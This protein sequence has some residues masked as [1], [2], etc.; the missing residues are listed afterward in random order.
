[1][2]DSK[3][4]VTNSAIIVNNYEPG[5]CVKLENNFKI[6]E[7]V[8]HSYY[9][10]GMHYD[11]DKKRLY[12]PRGIDIWYVEKLIGEKA[13]VLINQ[14]DKYH[15]YE[16]AMIKYLPR[17]ETQKKALRFMV[18]KEEY[19]KNQYKSQLSV[20]LSTGKG[21]TYLS[22]ATL[23]FLGIRGIII[24]ST[25]GWLD[26]WKD[27]TIEYTD[28]NP[29]DIYYISGSAN[30]SRL[31]RMKDK[32]LDRYK[33]FLVTHSTLR[34]YASNNGWDSI[35]ELFKK[36]QIGIK[37]FD[38]A[39][40]DFMNTCL[41]DFYT[42]TYK[43]YYLTATPNKSNERENDIYQLA[44]RNVPS[45]ELFDEDTDPHTSYVAVQFSSKPSAEQISKC[46]NKYGL[47]RN[48][49]TNYVVYQPEFYKL[50]TILL[51]LTWR[52]APGENDKILIY[53]GTNDAIRHTYD[54]VLDNF[55]ELDEMM[56][57][58]TS[59]ISPEEKMQALNKRF[60]FSTTKSAGAAL[61]IPGLKITINLAE[62]YKSEVIARQSLG[63][64]R[65]DNTYYIDAIDVGFEQCR[66]FYYKKL[67]IFEKYAK[68]CSVVKLNKYELDTRYENIMH[69]R[70]LTKATVKKRLFEY[71][72]PKKRL[73]EY[74]A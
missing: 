10:I 44:F 45:I 21:K 62:P 23:T 39:H 50:L 53:I 26:Q 7:P 52:L 65:D 69:A 28:M 33:L 51:D 74:L 37:I 72:Q 20:N 56:G 49:Y 19:Y 22:I 46:K 48:K 42:N 38:E 54:W 18:G 59:I 64:T 29:K 47:D 63:R 12:L 17:D 32:Q 55:P 41:I 73:F 35:G 30:I 4:V 68:D 9:Y 14:Y 34:S 1:M 6:F 8:T 5:D 27:K 31:F 25:T 61:D 36:L 60:I 15:T 66:R 70:E 67:P 16:D 58:Y 13:L 3:I 71:V 24:T 11:S 2:P 40:L 43:T 57:I